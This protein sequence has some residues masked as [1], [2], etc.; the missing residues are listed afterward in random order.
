MNRDDYIA[1]AAA[2]EVARVIQEG[3]HFFCPELPA[4]D[5]QR[6]LSALAE[7]TEEVAG[8][9]LALVGFGLSETDLRDRLNAM[10]LLV[11]HVTTD[12]H[13]AAKWRNEPDAHLNIIALA[14]GRYPGVSTLA[15]FPQGNARTFATRLLEWAQTDQA[16]LASTPAQ[17]R[18]LTALAEVPALSPLVSLNGVAEFLATWKA[19]QAAN[20][21]D[22]P[23]S[24]LPR[25]GVLPDRKLF[26]AADAIAER[27]S[28]NFRLTQALATMSGQRLAAIRT[29]IRRS[30]SA[31]RDRRLE[32]LKKVEEMRRTGGF[33]TY[34]ALDYEDARE[35]VTPPTEDPLP[36]SPPDPDGEPT[37]NGLPRE[38]LNKRD[39]SRDGGAA[40]VDG[41]DQALQDITDGVGEAMHD[42]IEDDADAASGEYAV[43]GNERRFEFTIDRELLTWVQFFCGPD[44]WGGFFETR[45]ASLEAALRDYGQC[46]PIRFRPG[47]SSIAHYGEM[48]DLRS[49]IKQMQDVL[50]RRGITSE[51]FCGLWDRIVAARRV[52]LNDLAFLLHQPVLATA[53]KPTLRTAAAELVQAWERL[54]DRLARHHAAMHDIDHAWTRMLLE[55]VASLDVVQIK[56]RLDARRSSWKAVLLPTHPLHLW[57]YERMATLARGL[58]PEEM[59]RVAVL[60]QLEQPE[61]YLG[62]LWLTSF[63]EGRGGGQPLPVAR[64]HCG[65]AVFENLRNAYS[66][67]DGIQALQRC[68]R[69][70]AQI[71]VNHTQPLRLALI[72][73]PQASEMLLTLLKDGRGRRAPGVTLLVD[74]YATQGHEARL[75][76]AR[77]FSSKDRDQIEEHIAN[78]RLRLRVHDRVTSLEEQLSSFHEKPVHI[79]AVFDE[80]STDMRQQPGGINLLPMSPFAMR[81]RIAYQ[82]IRG[83][84]ELLPSVDESV[85]RSFYD[86]QGKLHAQSGQTP[87][88]SADAEQMREHIES[89]LSDDRPGAFWFFFSDRALPSPGGTRVARILERRD[90]RRRSVCYDASYDRLAGLLRQ[91][92]DEFNIRVVP[93]QLEK[94][95]EEGVALLGDGLIDLFGPDGQPDTARVRGFAGML[96]AARDYRERHPEALLVSV[97]TRL[98][99]LWLR[100]SDTGERCDLLG[101][102]NEDG[103]MVVEAIEVKTAGSGGDVVAQAEIEKA[104]RQ[105]ASTLAAIQSGLEENEE[106]SPLAAPRQ[107]MLK[108]V[109]VSGCQTLGAG[110]EDR[111][112][113]VEW[114]RVVFHEIEGASETQLRGTVYAVEL[115]HNGPPE[116]EAVD[117]SAYEI[118]LRRVREARIQQ[119]LS[120]E[121]TPPPQGGD[122][123]GDPDPPTGNPSPPGGPPPAPTSSPED[124]AEAAPG[125]TVPVPSL[126][127]P[128]M[129]SEPDSDE[130]FGIRFSSG[131]S[132]SG[133]ARKLLYL[134][135][136]NTRLTQLNIGIVGDLGTG[137]TQ[138][139][140]ALIYRLTSSAAQNRGHAPKFLIF[141]Y[142]HDY[143]KA[144]FVKAVGARVVSPHHIPLN[145]FDLRT[146]GDHTPAARLGRVKFLNDAL[147][148]IYGGIGPRQ[149]NH[150]KT[151]VMQGYEA[152]S[153]GVPTLA[154]VL[155]AYESVI[156]DKVDAPYSILSDLV[157]LE[158]FVDRAVDA[159]HFNEFF[160]GV[161]VVD[162]ASL[163]IG[164]RER[165]MLL[166]LFLNL[167]YEYM[168][169][170]EKRPYVGQDPQLRF[171][172]SMLLVD[173]ADNIMKYNFDVLRQILLQGREF[174]VGVLLASQYLSHFRTRDTDYSEPLL[175]W[176]IHKVPNVTAR[177][178]ESIGLSKVASSTVE[179]VKGLD[180]NECLYKTL[181]VPGLF[182]RTLPFYSIST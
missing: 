94:L 86:M 106:S 46:E 125:I 96:I 42:A 174:G 107:E 32:I 119:L 124:A 69:Q 146:A 112:R 26:G 58:G 135:P 88:A 160:T 21:L 158:I 63:P 139:T 66:G 98:A 76:G 110:R 36:D 12:L 122:D 108:E 127:L 75:T 52:V 55:A 18:L 64:D 163:G 142:K 14:H 62:V 133:G 130:R 173:E 97:D 137:K 111:E 22:A 179:R 157:D 83:Q 48:H 19:A 29:R 165:N 102:R 3:G 95:L 44:D 59:D 149:R 41:D 182:M 23:R 93:Q 10:A 85:F 24:A 143:T 47:E 136:S 152:A 105:L 51:D 54:Y 138:L 166:V 27:L 80:A 140:K 33:D 159:Q 116:E 40:L 25:L 164:D 8:V 131:E 155:R 147:Q 67:S 128:P 70:F 56:T 45:N 1:Q 71:Y 144:D 175:T 162:L 121:T 38:T 87:Q 61:H 101:L 118:V 141:D 109:F 81:R 79:L 178:L 13:I 91:P 161:T 99:R 181:D 78:G 104:T 150:L 60:E 153:G 35:I 11:G 74:I 39:V 176:F 49:V 20:A 103:T 92:L 72:N 115:S 168:I 117:A 151:A 134:H 154:D 73:P 156:G 123:A 113:W 37:D 53:G 2:L 126:G 132:L 129:A 6:F 167:Y 180:V 172:D 28:Q 9:S 120:A 34:S 30:S 5:V 89:V 177:E 84:V 90:G 82:G 77:R 114:L 148:K 43:N 170:L 57:R 31:R 68:V 169:N 15:H 4:M 145:I 171:I 17:K 16:A 50:H 65:L 7:H 100:L